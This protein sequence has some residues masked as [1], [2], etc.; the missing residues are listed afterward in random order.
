MISFDVC[1]CGAP[2]QRIER[3]TPKPEG[4]QVLL[5]TL[6]AGICH[7]D[8]HIWDGFYEMGGGK[9][10]QLLDRGI[11]L[12]LT[13]GH[14]IAGEVV[15]VGADA[16]G[17][18][19]GDRRL[20]Y[21]WIGC[22]TCSVCKAGDE[23]L[24][25]APRFLG[26]FANGGY[27]DHVLV[28]DARY[29]LDLE[30]MAPEKA[31]PLACS[32]VTTYGALKKL[33]LSL[34]REPVVIIGAG[35][36][37]LMCLALAKMMG[38]PGAIVVDIDPVKRDAAMKAG[39]T[40]VVDGN[41]PDAT[42]QLAKLGNGAWSVIDLVGSSSTVRLGID[43]LAKGGK[44]IVVGLFGG[45]ITIS[46]PLIPMRALTIQGSYVGSLAELRELLAIV[47]RTGLPAQPVGTRS[48]ADAD[49]ALRELRA[50]KVVGR[51]V[52]TPN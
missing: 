2:L 6:A 24:C 52:L 39:A 43:C 34:Q 13:M 35:G 41:A 29:L 31:A 15:A 33:G 19:M 50:G 28:P 16:K 27:S 17:V 8:L 46:T 18:K 7:S 5:R 25:S 30:D 51:L 3:A 36:L 26:V 22:G 32:G 10:M 1:R 42:K 37:G 45:D 14:E 4:A 49:A 20:V 44:L 21:P 11:K 40:A 23:Q 12:P 48:F 9:R 47:K 38:S